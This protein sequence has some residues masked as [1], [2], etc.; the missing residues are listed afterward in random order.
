MVMQDETDNIDPLF[1]EQLSTGDSERPTE[2]E[3]YSLALQHP[4]IS[5]VE[6]DVERS[7]AVQAYVRRC[8]ENP[9]LV[10]ELTTSCL[11]DNLSRDNPGTDLMDSLNR[12][13]SKKPMT[14]TASEK[15]MLRGWLTQ[16]TKVVHD[17]SNQ[18]LIASCGSEPLTTKEDRHHLSMRLEQESYENAQEFH[19]AEEFGGDAQEQDDKYQDA[20]ESKSHSTAPGTEEHQDYRPRP[21]ERLPDDEDLGALCELYSIDPRTLQVNPH[22]E[23]T[24]NLPTQIP[25][26]HMTSSCGTRTS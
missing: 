7:E 19:G 22:V 10:S 26:K 20:D 12:D 9:E 6:D 18:D 14:I 8:K 21:N 1:D 2:D 25:G 17:G 5:K 23:Q 13:P 24:R 11:V 16:I 4:D 3:L 15:N